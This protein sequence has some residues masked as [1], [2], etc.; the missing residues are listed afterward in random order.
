MFLRQPTDI[1]SRSG[2]K[3]NQL[4]V[5]QPSLHRMRSK[6]SVGMH[7][8]HYPSRFFC[9]LPISSKRIVIHPNNE[10]IL[11]IVRTLQ[12]GIERRPMIFA[13]ADL[14][15]KGWFCGQWNS[16][17]SI[18]VGYANQGIDEPHVHSQITE[19]YLVARGAAEIRVEQETIQLRSGDMIVLVPGEAHTFL[20]SSPDYFHFVL[21]T[22]GLAGELA[23]REKTPVS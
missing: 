12:S 15:K 4:Q 11:P 17:L 14:S 13:H 9:L 10:K 20:S 22:P 7:G 8:M 3:E 2:W 19:I 6:K 21:H 16:D 18:S 5:S 23:L 1:T